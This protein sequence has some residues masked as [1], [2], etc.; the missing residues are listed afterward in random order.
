MVEGELALQVKTVMIC[1]GARERLPE[2]QQ[3]VGAEEI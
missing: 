1:N 3:K 2:R